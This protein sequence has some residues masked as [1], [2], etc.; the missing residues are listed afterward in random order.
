M[1]WACAM[2]PVAPGV[3]AG[4][5]HAGPIRKLPPDCHYVRTDRSDLWPFKYVR[6]GELFR[7]GRSSS[8]MSVPL[9]LN[10]LPAMFEQ[11]KA[12]VAMVFP[13]WSDLPM[14][15]QYDLVCHGERVL[16]PPTF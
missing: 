8:E 12:L 9:D 3:H 15:R 10:K 7:D 1:V 16:Q 11:P 5:I 4:P 6:L 13:K 2:G 14:F